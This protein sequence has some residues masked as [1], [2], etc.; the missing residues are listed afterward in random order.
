MKS[1]RQKMIVMKTVKPEILRMKI[2][3]VVQALNFRLQTLN[4]KHLTMRKLSIVLIVLLYIGKVSAQKS[5]VQTA[6]NYL[7]YEQLDKAKEA[8]DKAA[9]NEA[10]MGMEKTW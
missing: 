10:S 9:V 6:W 3:K 2:I 4:F 8:I 1:H 5:E 7:K